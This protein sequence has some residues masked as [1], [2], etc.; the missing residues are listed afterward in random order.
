MT[1]ETDAART[2]ALPARLFC[3]NAKY[4]CYSEGKRRLA[5]YSRVGRS[6]AEK[7]ELEPHIVES[8]GFEPLAFR[9]REE[10]RDW[11]AVHQGELMTRLDTGESEP[12][13][14]VVEEVPAPPQIIALIAAAKA[15][16][17]AGVTTTRAQASTGVV[18]HVYVEYH[19]YQGTRDVP[20]NGRVMSFDEDGNAIGPIEFATRE[21]AQSWIRAKSP[22]FYWL[23]HG[24]HSSPTYSVRKAPRTAGS[25]PK[26]SASSA[27]AP[28]GLSRVPYGYIALLRLDGRISGPTHGAGIHIPEIPYS[29]R[30][31]RA[32]VTL[33]HEEDVAGVT[34]KTWVEAR[35]TVRAEKLTTLVRWREAFDLPLGA[36]HVVEGVC[37]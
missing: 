7:K 36:W 32:V 27:A 30:W 37:A 23:R 19:F 16:A 24:E 31:G 28:C 26:I 15:T 21:A 18:F 25:R 11:I 4:Y 29:Q 2:P 14:Y 22:E 6:N 5:D 10:A 9:T 3:I 35:R 13:T 12:R 8:D 17:T 1:T 20:K 33:Q 34:T